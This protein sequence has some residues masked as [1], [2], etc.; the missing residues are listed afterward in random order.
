MKRIFSLGLVAYL[1]MSVLHAEVLLVEDFDYVAGTPL[2]ECGWSIPYESRY[3]AT[4]ISNGL[5]FDG[6]AGCGIGNGALIS[7]DDGSYQPHKAFAKQ[8][9]GAIYVAFM[10]NPYTVYKDCYFL[11]LRDAITSPNYNFVA[12][13]CLNTSNQIGLA[14]KAGTTSATFA[15]R[16]LDNETTYLVV[17]KYEIVEGENND[18]VSLYLLDQFAESE[19]ITPLLSVVSTFD[20]EPENVV[21][22]SS[23]DDNWILVDGIRVATTWSEA[24]AAGECPEASAIGT[25]ENDN[26][27]YYSTPNALH[28]NI[29]NEEEIFIYDTTGKC[30]SHEFLSSGNYRFE[31]Q[32][33][34]YV[35][36]T[37]RKTY[38]I[39]IG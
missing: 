4:S 32:K 10:M 22:C 16:V 34:F 5:S 15:D 23:T 14:Y 17:L 2:S 21:L 30:V 9:Q 24:V 28:L 33:G 3:T 12:R 6:Y 36:K 13:V 1:A 19:P 31:L 25:T 27:S 35:L 26:L 38:K 37:Q 18:R 29:A 11:T 8:T 20:I 39:I 7:G